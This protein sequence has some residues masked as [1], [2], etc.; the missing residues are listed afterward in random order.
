MFF[1]K[2]DVKKPINNNDTTDVISRVLTYVKMTT[3][4]TN[5]RKYKNKRLVNNIDKNLGFG[6][7]ILFTVAF[8]DLPYLF[9]DEVIFVMADLIDIIYNI[10]KILYNY[11]SSC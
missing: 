9:I 6:Y 2:K 7:D 4:V 3:M 5:T 11:R 8:M 10:A 1:V